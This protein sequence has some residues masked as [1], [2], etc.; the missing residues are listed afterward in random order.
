LPRSFNRW[1]S[2]L[3]LNP[4][5]RRPNLRR[6]LLQRPVLSF[7]EHHVDDAFQPGYIGSQERNQFIG[8]SS[9]Y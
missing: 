6:R 5:Q 9:T 8:V 3:A 1:H 4:R 2:K 7:L